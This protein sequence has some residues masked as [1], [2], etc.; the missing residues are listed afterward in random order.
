MI[1]GKDSL[2]CKLKKSLYGL[3]QAPQ[4]WYSIITSYLHE[5]GFLK[6]DVDSNLYFKLVENQPLVQVLYAD[7]IFLTGEEILISKC[8]RELTSEFEMKYLGLMHYFLGLEIWQRNAE[9]FISQGKYTMDI[10]H[11]FG[12]VDCKSINTP[13]DSNLRKIHETET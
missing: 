11:R 9:I 1:L 5:L 6:S 2:V 10:L 8:Q 7:D 4:A 3:K 13:M 12:T